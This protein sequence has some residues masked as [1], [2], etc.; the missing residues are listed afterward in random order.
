MHAFDYDTI[1]GHKIIVRRAEDGEKFQTL[2]GQERIMDKDVNITTEYIKL[3]QL[4]KFSG[5][6]AIGSDA[7]E[8]LVDISSD[9][10]KRMSLFIYLNS[11]LLEYCKVNTT[12]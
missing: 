10:Q 5:A 8:T 2:D 9:K 7:K 6:V 4:L 11:F 12:Y 1:A 3:D